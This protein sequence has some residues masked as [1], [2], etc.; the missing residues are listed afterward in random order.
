MFPVNIK[1]K[2]NENGK[3]F[4]SDN[5]QEENLAKV[6]LNSQDDFIYIDEKDAAIFDRFADLLKWLDEKG[7]DLS[8]KEKEIESQYG[9][10]IV[11]RDED[12]DIVDF[13]IDAFVALSKT[14]TDTY[15]EA[16]AKIDRIFGQDV[17]RKYFR[18]SYEINP[19]FVPDDECI[20]DFLD[21]MTPV[22]NQIYADRAKRVKLKYNR[23]R[24]GG[25]RTRYRNKEELIQDYMR[26]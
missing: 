13:N 14:R 26:K 17:I 23:D 25:K 15:R 3:E 9:K 8:K 18:L 11:T 21:S 2:G 5:R 12:G 10:D 19:D 16:A 24:K 6:F 20:Y 1:K 22:L 4:R 7:N